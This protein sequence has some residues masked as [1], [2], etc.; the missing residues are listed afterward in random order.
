MHP[1]RALRRAGV[2][3]KRACKEQSLTEPWR[4]SRGGGDPGVRRDVAR[5]ILVDKASV[6]G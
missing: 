2:A 5:D 3:A 4:K 6:F 1:T